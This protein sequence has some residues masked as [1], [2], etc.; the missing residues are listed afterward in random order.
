MIITKEYLKSIKPKN[1]SESDKYSTRIYKY[2]RKLESKDVKI[3]K[4]KSFTQDQPNDIL[5]GKLD[6]TGSLLAIHLPSLF[7]SQKPFDK[8][9]V[10]YLPGEFDTSTEMSDPWFM[11]YQKIGRCIYLPHNFTWIE[12]G[13]NRFTQINATIRQCNWCGLKEEKVQ[14]QV[15]ELK[16]V[17]KPVLER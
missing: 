12:G 4:D 2:L 3:Y 9:L 14:V 6:L 5:I 7:C 13:D 10:E 1:L 11:N 17:W 15:Q 16:E 8:L